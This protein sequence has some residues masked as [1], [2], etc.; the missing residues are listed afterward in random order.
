MK[1]SFDELWALF[2]NPDIKDF[3]M[4]KKKG[5]FVNPAAPF[6][7]A[8]QSGNTYVYGLTVGHVWLIHLIHKHGYQ[9][10]VKEI[11][12]LANELKNDFLEWNIGEIEAER[13]NN[14]LSNYQLQFNKI[15][16]TDFNPLNYNEELNLI[17]EKNHPYHAL[18]RL[19][20]MTKINFEGLSH[21]DL[22]KNIE[23]VLTE[24][25]TIINSMYLMCL[26][27][28]LVEND[29]DIPGHI[30]EVLRE[31]SPCGSTGSDVKYYPNLAIERD[32]ITLLPKFFS[33]SWEWFD[34]VEEVLF[35]KL[36]YSFRV[37]NELRLSLLAS[38]GILAAASTRI[39]FDNYWQTKFLIEKEE[40]LKY[41]EFTLD[42]MRLHILKRLNKE[43][44]EVKD[45]NIL[46]LASKNQLLDPIP[47]NGDYFK[48][49][50][51]EYAIELG[52]KDDYDLYYEYNSEFIHA[53]LTAVF[54]GIMTECENPEHSN[55]LTISNS[56]SRY[57]DTM[58][59]I[60]CILN[61]HI[62]LINEYVGA[63]IIEELNFKDYF[64]T[65]R[66]EFVKGME[67]IKEKS[68]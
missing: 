26:Q 68:E 58:P 37:V 23:E 65:D 13:I 20:H 16:V 11:L 29:I 8:K 61:K 53:S 27:L 64:F 5:L 55:H 46:M 52:I 21:I 66:E 62:T 63:N 24:E 1:K 36:I 25:S 34:E 44:K 54:S 6:T 7:E 18:S 49:S 32:Y 4:D 31:F 9:G 14:I 56:T 35:S 30:Q 50:A 60:F 39:L 19:L 2:E 17:K 45:I 67:S 10:F 12:D 33:R 28:N 57:I 43:E 51:R 41:R 59:H 48:K 38:N 47:I 22:T 3:Q 40:V 15:L 42:R